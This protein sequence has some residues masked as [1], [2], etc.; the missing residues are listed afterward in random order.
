M[1][2]QAPLN[3]LKNSLYKKLYGQ[4]LGNTLIYK[5]ITHH[6]ESEPKKALAIGMHGSTGT[7]KNYA[8]QMIAESIY[9]KGMSSPLVHVFAGKGSFPVAGD[10]DIYKR[11]L[12]EWISGNVSRCHYSMFVFDECDKYPPT[13]L[14]VVMPFIDHHATF[15]GVDYR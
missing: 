15:G 12:V 8:A 6:L 10:V 7:G 3:V 14:D 4:H 11:N 2:L 13:L 5:A 1:V 9:K